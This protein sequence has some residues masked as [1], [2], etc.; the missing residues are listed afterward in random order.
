MLTVRSSPTTR[1]FLRSCLIAGLLGLVACYPTYNWRELSVADGLAVL[2]FPGKVETAQRDIEL[3][4]IPVTFVLSGTEV[5]NTVFSVGHARLPGKTTET[6]RVAVKRALV[7]S[8]ASGM[9]QNAPEQ[10]Y[11]GEVFRLEAQ[12]SDRS[13]VMFAR[14][15]VHYDVAMRVVASGP[16]QELTDEL[17]GE[18][19][20]SLKLR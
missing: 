3:A 18:F 2:A 5:K 6:E 1:L 15:L 16:P 14:V 20:R 17:A 7:D 11:Q 13:L 4:G 12:V 9:S 19:M 8:L 10:A